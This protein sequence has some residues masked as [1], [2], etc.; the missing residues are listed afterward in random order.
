MKD[1]TGASFKRKVSASC[2]YFASPQGFGGTG[3]VNTTL[4]ERPGTTAIKDE[5]KV[6]L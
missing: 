4:L 2:D 6:R 1:V 3:A 5:M